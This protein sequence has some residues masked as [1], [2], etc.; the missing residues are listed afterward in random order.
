MCYGDFMKRYISNFIEENKQSIVTLSFCILLGLIVG[1]IFYFFIDSGTKTQMLDAIKNT[2][3]LAKDQNFQ[4]INII[5]NGIVTNFTMIVIIMIATLTMI[6]PII[7]CVI[8]FLKGFSLGIYICVLFSVLNLGNG[9]IAT[10]TYVLIPNLILLPI[11]I[12]IGVNA[13]NFHYQ[14]S[15]KG[16]NKSKLA[17]FVKYM[18]QI[19][20]AMPFIFL[21]IILEQLI[22]PLIIYLYEKI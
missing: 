18:Y 10:L 21:S 12:Y 13:I 3:N 8:Y 19:A 17:S 11:Y 14:I 5:K 1:I 15:D 22:S 6:A 2:F 20:T 16:E 4:D 9:I 7:V